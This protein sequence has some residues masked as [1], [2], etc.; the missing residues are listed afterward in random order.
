ALAAHGVLPLDDTARWQRPPAA[1]ATLPEAA[2]V[3]A[4]APV[5]APDDGP[6]EPALRR[7]WSM[8][9]GLLPGYATRFGAGYVLT[10]GPDGLE[11]LRAELLAAAAAALDPQARGRVAAALGATAV[12]D[13]VPLDDRPGETI[14][15]V[16]VSRI[17]GAV[18]RV[19]LARRTIAASGMPATVQALASPAFR[20]AIDAVVES[21]GGSVEYGG[22]AAAL[23]AGPP[24]RLV[25]EFDA[26]GPG[27]LVVRQSFVKAWR[28]EI[29]G[30]AA[31]VEP[32][33]GAHVGVR[34][35][36][37]R[38]RATIRLDPRRYLLGAAGPLLF[39][40][41]WLL[42]PR[43]RSSTGRAAASDAPGRSSPASRPAP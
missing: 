35:P 7:F 9:A 29:D 21:G 10:R 27:L 32:V 5:A 8:R 30:A 31:A 26:A 15:G 4:F 16:V 6:A 41:V 24:H 38:H 36:P 33:N 43:G 12:V 17:A 34:V 3:A 37:G 20:P 19:Y 25:V 23:G 28:A 18:P 14:D 1:L 39:L 2:T 22:G 40:A 42:S 11:P 13:T